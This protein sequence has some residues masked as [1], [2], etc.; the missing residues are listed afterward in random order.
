MNHLGLLLL[1]TALL[2]LA[3]GQLG[4]GPVDAV[5]GHPAAAL[6][7][8]QLIVA[9]ALLHRPVGVRLVKFPSLRIRFI[10][11][12]VGYVKQIVSVPTG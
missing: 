10:F 7:V 5:G 12:K 11:N 1:A 3:M 6:L 2:V 9:A 8:G 4:E